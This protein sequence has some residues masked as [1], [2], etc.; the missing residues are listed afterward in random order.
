MYRKITEDAEKER[1]EQ[2]VKD[3]DEWKSLDNKS[4]KFVLDYLNN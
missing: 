3:W 4:K 2:L 1:A